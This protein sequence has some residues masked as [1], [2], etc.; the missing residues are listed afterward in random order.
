MGLLFKSNRDKDIDY[1]R[2]RNDLMDEYGAQMVTFTGA[3]G[4][5]D[6]CDAQEA[7]NEELIKMAQREGI[8]IDR[9][10]KA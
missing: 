10:R 6:M 5:S 3:V 1:E 8:N 9:Y 2:L 4:Y 7:S